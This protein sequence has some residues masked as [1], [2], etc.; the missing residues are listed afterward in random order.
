[1]KV[2]KPTPAQVNFK[3]LAEAASEGNKVRVLLKRMQ[4]VQQASIAKLSEPSKY[5]QKLAEMIRRLNIF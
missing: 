1:M 2:E 3:E 4:E 5:T